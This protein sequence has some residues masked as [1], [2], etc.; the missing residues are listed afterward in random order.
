MGTSHGQTYFDLFPS[1]MK[2]A[3]VIYNPV[4]GVKKWKNVPALIQETLHEHGYKWTWYDTKSKQNLAPLFSSGYNRV[5]VSGGDGTI[6]EVVKSMVHRHE[7]TPLVILPQ[8]SG[9]LLARALGIPLMQ[10][11]RALTMGLTEKPQQLDVMRI[12]KHH[13]GVIAVGRGYDTFLMQ[14]T[15]RALKRKLG[16]LAYLWTFIKTFLFYRSKPYK[17]TFDKKRIQVLAKFIMVFNIL[18]V[19]LT[20]IRPNDGLLNTLILTSRGRIQSFTSKTVVIK[21]KKEQKFEV[22]GDV[23]RSKVISIEALPKALSIVFKKQL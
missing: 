4:S 11:R 14:E 6:A 22:D 23:F 16:L 8:G 20:S 2:R 21:A 19:P 13:Y 17:L 18:P 12:N 5:V 3:L 1:F 10:P 15:P 9:N 7:K